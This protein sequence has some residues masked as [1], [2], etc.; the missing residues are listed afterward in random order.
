MAA[1]EVVVMRRWYRSAADRRERGT[2]AHRAAAGS[3]P[4][5]TIPGRR[6]RDRGL[7]TG[8]AS[9]RRRARGRL[10]AGGRLIGADDLGRGLADRV[11]RRQVAEERLEAFG[12]DRLFRDELF[13]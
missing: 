4:E 2:N 1:E 6:A 3:L 13:R 12:I 11:L 7:R 5:S 9:G 10:G 8:S